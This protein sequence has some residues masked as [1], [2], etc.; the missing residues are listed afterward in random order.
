MASGCWK[1]GVLEVRVLK[2]GTSKK[3]P[4]KRERER[5]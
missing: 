1:T 5:V 2:K 3:E 4:F